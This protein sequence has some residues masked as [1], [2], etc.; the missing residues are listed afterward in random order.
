VYFVFL[1]QI[2]AMALAVL[3]TFLIRRRRLASAVARNGHVTRDVVKMEAVQW[4]PLMTCARYT[5]CLTSGAVNH[6]ALS[7]VNSTILSEDRV[8]RGKKWVAVQLTRGVGHLQASVHGNFGH[9]SDWRA[10]LICIRP[11]YTKCVGFSD[12][13]SLCGTVKLVNTQC[14]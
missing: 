11:Y 9:L 7:A 3:L 8:E 4:L 1:F 14:F 13:P 6:A 5:E 10:V 12:R 2:L